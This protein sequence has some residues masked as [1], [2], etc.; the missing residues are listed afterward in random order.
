MNHSAFFGDGDKIFALP[1][2]QIHELEK[3][4]GMP[5][6]L[7]CQR[8]PEGVFRLIE[9]TETI[10]LSLIGGGMSPKDAARYSDSY[11]AKRP[12]SES[13]PIAVAVLQIVWLGAPAQADAPA[14]TPDEEATTNG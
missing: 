1:T 4:T 7:L 10:R 11:A 2:D 5:I 6:G 12:L 3:T 8:L 9:L 13:F 14:S